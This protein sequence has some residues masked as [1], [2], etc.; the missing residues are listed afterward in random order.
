MSKS[1]IIL[2]LCSLSLNVLAQEQDFKWP[3]GK[4]MAISLTWDDARPSQV[5][6]GTAILNEY[7]TKATFYVLPGPVYDELGGWKQAV[8]DGHEIGNHSYNHP[9]SGNFLWARKN[10]LEGYSEEKM[11]L[12]L[13][14]ANEK[15]FQ[16]LGVTPTQFAYPCGQTFINRG[17]ETESYVP[18]ISRNFE[19]GRTWLDEVA[20]DPAFCDLAQ[21]TGVEMDGKSFKEILALIETARM[22]GLWLVLA[23]HEINKDGPQTTRTKTLEKLLQYLNETPEIWVAPVGEITEYVRGNRE[24]E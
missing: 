20:N 14:A 4:Q 23:G 8:K 1:L 5:Q 16:M 22:D 21:L 12:E 3:E 17:T 2:F 9:C 13:E 19:S 7:D 24:L 10:A 6:I 18:I 15:L 11:E